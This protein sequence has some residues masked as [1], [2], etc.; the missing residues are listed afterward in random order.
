MGW[1]RRDLVLERK[2]SPK[3]REGLAKVG[4]TLEGMRESLRE[5]GLLQTLLEL[6]NRAINSVKD[7]LETLSLA[8]AIKN[9][10]KS[11]KMEKVN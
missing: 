2:A 1:C 5:K 9:S 8:I 4:L 7:D 3:V 6:R 11:K 10:S